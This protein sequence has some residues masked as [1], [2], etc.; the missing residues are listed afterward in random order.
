MILY[1][2]MIGVLAGAGMITSARLLTIV[3]ALSCG[4]VSMEDADLNRGRLNGLS[5]VMLVLGV[6]LTLLAGLMTVTWPLKANPPVNIA[7]GEPA[8]LLG[9]LLTGAGFA[10]HHM[11]SG[12]HSYDVTPAL[13]LVAVAGLILVAV[14]SAVFSYNL[15]GD[16]PRAEPITGQFTGWENTTFG[17]VYLLAGV[18]CLAAPWALAS[19]WA[20]RVT[21]WSFMLAGV[22]F[23]AFSVLNYRTHI[24]LLVNL[25]RGTSYRW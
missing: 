20:R 15:I 25:E 6:P 13:Y 12:N 11:R 5:V 18:G 21:Y 24:G 16:A 9:L 10:L 2:T 3:A 23:L 22:F 19:R 17:V 4:P 8:L 7:F 14:S 1:N